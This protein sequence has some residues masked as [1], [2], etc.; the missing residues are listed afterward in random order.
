MDV[1]DEEF[2]KFWSALK[3]CN[4]KYIM[5]GGVAT[6]LHGY[7]RTTEDIDI[8]IDDA[9]ENRTNFRL[10]LKKYSGTDYFMIERM[11]FVAGWTNFNL[12]N[13]MRL[14]VMTHLKGL[15]EFSFDDCFALASIA[16]INGVAVPFLHINH[17][18]ESKKAAN[19]PKDQLDVIYLEKIKQLQ[20]GPDLSSS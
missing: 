13:G 9:I 17:L 15:E 10:A 19:R 2:I 11:Q 18:I 7:Q 16:E 8:W 4:V 20:S 1:F 3:K 14:D 5:V 6:N 12:N